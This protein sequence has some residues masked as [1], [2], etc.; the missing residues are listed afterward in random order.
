MTVYPVAAFDCSIVVEELVADELMGRDADLV[1]EMRRY[2]GCECC[3]SI[4]NRPGFSVNQHVKT[5]V[6]ELSHMLLRV[7]REDDD[8]ALTYTEE[9]LV[10]ESIAY[11]VCGSL[12]LDTSSYS[13]RRTARRRP[14]AGPG[15]GPAWTS[16][17]SVAGRPC[18]TRGDLRGDPR[19]SACRHS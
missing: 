13:M 8:L 19:R 6:H 17:R 16:P 18:P 7:E 15:A 5:M 12:G 14:G 10:V 1:D 2:V 11:T 9:E 3:L 4:N